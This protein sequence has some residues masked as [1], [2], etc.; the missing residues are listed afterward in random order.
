MLA[1]ADCLR[2]PHFDI[3]AS[4]VKLPREWS[5]IGAFFKPWDTAW[6]TPKWDTFEFHSATAQAF[7]DAKP[8]SDMLSEASQHP[9]DIL[10]YTD[11][12]ANEAAGESGFGVLILLKIGTAFRGS[13][14]AASRKP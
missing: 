1:L 3:T 14:R 5:N 13:W 6:L 11:G 12:S 7:Q 10:L 8:W 4:T 9:T 2:P